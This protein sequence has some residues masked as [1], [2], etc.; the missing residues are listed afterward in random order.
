MAAARKPVV[1]RWATVSSGRPFW[2]VLLSVCFRCPLCGVRITFVHGINV[3]TLHF[4]A[5]FILSC[6]ITHLQPIRTKDQ[7]IH[8]QKP[9]LELPIHGFCSNHGRLV[10]VLQSSPSFRFPIASVLQKCQE[11]VEEHECDHV[12]LIELHLTNQIVEIGSRRAEKSS[13]RRIGIDVRTLGD[14]HPY[15]RSAHSAH[16]LRTAY[17]QR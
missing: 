5:M 15:L 2:S 16:I 14:Q 4:S 6:A 10:A 7:E 12:H 3:W 9:Q 8:R 1:K 11:R 13:F 17:V